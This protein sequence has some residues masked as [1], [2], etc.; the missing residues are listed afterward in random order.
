MVSWK[1]TYRRFNFTIT[2]RSDT[3]NSKMDA[4]SV[5]LSPS[6]TAYRE[7]L[8]NQEDL[9]FHCVLLDDNFQGLGSLPTGLHQHRTEIFL[10]P[11]SAQSLLNL[12]PLK[13]DGSCFFIRLCGLLKHFNNRSHHPSDRR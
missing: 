3:R 5:Q 13:G 4:L 1:E 11:E 9:D 2:Y 7:R 12:S 10:Q 8:Q 6:E